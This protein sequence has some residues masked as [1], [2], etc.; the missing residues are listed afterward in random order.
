MNDDTIADLKQFIAT[1][2]KQ[3]VAILDDKIDSMDEKFLRLDEKIDNKADEILSAIADTTNERF[4]LVD[5]DVKSLDIRV[6]KLE[7][8]HA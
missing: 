2:L 8:N 4:E 6:T 5:E 3:E 7:S 1:T